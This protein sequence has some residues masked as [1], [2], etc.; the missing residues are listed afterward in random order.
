ME[1]SGLSFLHH[2]PIRNIALTYA[3]CVA[4]KEEHQ[5]QRVPP[6][7]FAA[8][9][10]AVPE[11][12]RSTSLVGTPNGIDRN[13]WERVR[14]GRTRGRSLGAWALLSGPVSWVRDS[15]PL[16]QE[17]GGKAPLMWR[18]PFSCGFQWA[19]KVPISPVKN[20]GSNVSAKLL[21]HLDETLRSDPFMTFSWYLYKTSG[22]REHR[23]DT[24]CALSSTFLGRGST[25]ARRPQSF[26]VSEDLAV[27]QVQ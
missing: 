21:R 24:A 5:R 3:S 1:P 14:R 4:K 26:A 27:L 12:L 16:L 20:C 17:E 7:S 13:G 18:S 8:P 22:A 10:S 15:G 25:A 23:A 19:V 11:A 2:E 6:P 9:A